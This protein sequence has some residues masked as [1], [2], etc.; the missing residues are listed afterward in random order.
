MNTKLLD[1]LCTELVQT[2][3]P[4]NRNVFL[5]V[6]EK[7]GLSAP[8][9]SAVLTLIEL[10]SSV[11]SVEFFCNTLFECTEIL[12]PEIIGQELKRFYNSAG[13][14]RDYLKECTLHF[15]EKQETKCLK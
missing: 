6:L 11:C 12:P 1:N 15:L 13:V 9:R 4:K 14:I 8:V 3:V 2:L 7:K 5:G 10:G